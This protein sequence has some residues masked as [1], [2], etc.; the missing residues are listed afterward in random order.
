METS[1]N[2]LDNMERLNS[3]KKEDI[4]NTEDEEDDR[5]AATVEQSHDEETDVE[6][7]DRTDDGINSSELKCTHIFNDQLNS[8]DSTQLKTRN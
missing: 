6:K 8:S 7:V 1:G 4:H 2:D 3:I 5:N